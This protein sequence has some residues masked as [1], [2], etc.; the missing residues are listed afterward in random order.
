MSL[1]DYVESRLEE[2]ETIP[3]A[4]RD[5]L[6]Q[7]SEFVRN[8]GRATT[9]LLFVCTHNSRRSQMAQIWAAAAASHCGVDRVEFY[10]GGTEATAFDRRAV[11][12]IERAGLQVAK[13]TGD[14]N[15]TY[16]ITV[17]TMTLLLFSKTFDASA[18]PKA[19]F[20]AVMTCSEVDVACP[21]MPG[22][23]VR[24]LLPYEDPKHYDGA[25]VESEK[26]DEGCREISREMLYVFSRARS[27]L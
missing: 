13:L 19:E 15:P 8:C 4:R 12:A 16:R 22:A 24:I 11:A 5:V 20:C 23:S 18:N 10:S 14:S 3:P 21:S 9:R 27:R 1:E 6:D 17:G 7:L 2:L 26:Y 25:E